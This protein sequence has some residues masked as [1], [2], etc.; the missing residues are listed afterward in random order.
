MTTDF[1]PPEFDWRGWVERH[2]SE[3]TAVLMTTARDKTG[4]F[5][6]V[7][8]LRG[9]GTGGPMR[10]WSSDVLFGHSDTNTAGGYAF[11]SAAQEQQRIADFIA[12]VIRNNP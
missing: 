5:Y 3:I 9:P 1:D 2:R 6:T 11:T 4:V 8:V 10:L 7:S 12:N